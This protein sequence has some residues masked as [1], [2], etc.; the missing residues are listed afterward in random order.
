MSKNLRSTTIHPYTEAND[1][2]CNQDE[3]DK[4]MHFVNLVFVWR[5]VQ[6]TI[7]LYID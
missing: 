5:H 7:Y 4:E 6:S 2:E 3:D 1:N